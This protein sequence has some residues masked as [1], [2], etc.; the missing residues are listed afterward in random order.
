MSTFIHGLA[1]LVLNWENAEMPGSSV[2]TEE[3]YRFKQPG[4]SAASGLVIRGGYFY[5]VGDDDLGL[6]KLP[7]HLQSS[8]LRVPLLAGGLPDEPKARK[9]AKPDWESLVHL[10]E[11]DAILCL[12]SGSTPHRH[13]GVL[14]DCQDQSIE[15]SFERTYQALRNAVPDL[16]IEGAVV[17]GRKIRVF[18]RGNGGAGFNALIDLPLDSFLSD[19]VVPFELKSV[20]LGSMTDSFQW[21]FTD[22]CR[23]GDF[24]WF[25]AVSE[26]TRSTYEDGAFS[27]ARLGCMDLAGTILDVRT[28]DI[29]F[30]PEGLANVGEAFYLVT[31]A[32]DRSVPSRIYRLKF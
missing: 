24:I 22:A 10:P 8:E 4:L 28:L 30:K 9:T 19:E 27:G 15:L 26:E 25:L 18:Q 11:S 1:G 2:A 17:I 14:V 32:D 21:G 31:D 29:P 3:I 12:P 7:I 6:F 13:R 5:C 23:V 16:N 20:E